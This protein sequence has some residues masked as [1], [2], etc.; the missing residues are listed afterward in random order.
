MEKT[1]IKD[2]RE[3]DTVS[4]V[5][6][7]DSAHQ[8]YTKNN[9]AY[10]KL[11]LT[12]KTGQIESVMWEE[13][14]E[15]N[16]DVLAL[17][18]GDFVD[19]TGQAAVNRYANRVEVVLNHVRQVSADDI[20][21]LDFLPK[22]EADIDRLKEQ[23]AELIGQ[24]DDAQVK[25]L[26]DAVFGDLKIYKAY[27]LAPA[28]KTY[29]HAYLGGLLEHS[30]SVGGL[31]LLLCGHYPGLNKSLLIAGALLHD[32]GKIREFNYA[33]H[34]EY[35]TEGRLK[36]HIVMGDQIVSGIADKIKGLSDDLKLQISHLILS[37]HGEPEYGAAVRSKTKEAVILNIIDNA[38]AKANG[39]I[40]IAK[41]Y[42]E[43]VE[44]TDFQ[45]MFGDYLYLGPSAPVPPAAQSRTPAPE[46]EPE[47]ERA[48]DETLF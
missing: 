26:L 33:T 13:T 27:C 25:K 24:V 28:A 34:I 30:V 44:W 43:G 48:T 12:D 38:D 32:I 37:H 47:P 41:K 9:K 17:K 39:W 5:F 46:P 4:G 40:Q 35:S 45:S 42:E 22:T 15:K 16:P 36:G 21:V 11:V 10:F 23:L 7:V 8:R 18:A 29:H 20:D 19:L 14:M 1:Y 2:I 6:L 3:G 31:A